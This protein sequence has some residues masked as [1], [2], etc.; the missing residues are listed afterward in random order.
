MRNKFLLI[1][2]LLILS[3]CTN[4]QIRDE[5]QQKTVDTVQKDTTSTTR[6]DMVIGEPPFR[7]INDFNAKTGN[8]FFDSL[9]VEY[10][11]QKDPQIELTK[12][13][14]IGDYC[15]SYQTILNKEK[16]AVLY[17]FRG[18]S[19][20]YGFS[21][22]QY[23]LISDSLA[24][25]RNFLINV[26]IEPTLDK[27]TVWKIEEKMYDFRNDQPIFTRKYTFTN[28]LNQFDLT[29]KSM[30][31]RAFNANIKETYE[32]KLGE[33]KKHLE[34]RKSEYRE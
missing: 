22:D 2:T 24:V 33:L 16:K 26:E 11:H 21:N 30:K 32:E 6:M 28:N 1:P 12:D 23:F 8:K 7:D 34:R 31:A 17:F 15:E 27:P 25:V 19:G 20:E 5:N 14:C 13:I 3:N 9:H 29:L 4:T 18:S 10:V